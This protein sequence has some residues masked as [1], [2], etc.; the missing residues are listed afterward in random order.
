MSLKPRIRQRQGTDRQ[1]RAFHSAVCGSRRTTAKG[2]T[3]QN[4]ARAANVFE[5]ERI[6]LCESIKFLLVYR[7]RYEQKSH[8]QRGLRQKVS[9]RTFSS[10]PSPAARTPKRT[11]TDA[12]FIFHPRPSTQSQTLSPTP[13]NLQPWDPRPYTPYPYTIHPKPLHP[14]PE[15]PK[16]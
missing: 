1:R 10:K 14:K 15:N 9:R 12:S 6:T 3:G 7:V 2:Q 4:A 8:R 13:Q 11:P 5:R 16:P